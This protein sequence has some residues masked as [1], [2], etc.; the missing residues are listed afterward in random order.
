MLH[1]DELESLFQSLDTDFSGQ[2]SFD[3]FVRGLVDIRN[4]RQD[5]TQLEEQLEED[6]VIN[7]AYLD[8]CAAF[9]EADFQYKGQLDLSTFLEAM[10][11]PSVAES[12]SYA[13][14]L[15][16]GYFQSLGKI[17]KERLFKEIDK[18]DSGA[19]SFEE[20]VR[21]LVDAR[22]A[23]YQQEKV[24]QQEAEFA[25]QLAVEAFEDADDDWS[26][27]L[28]IEKFTHAFKFNSSFLSKVSEA[29]GVDVRDLAEFQ[30]VDIEDLFQK[31]DVDFSG[32][33]S[34]Q[35]FVSGLMQA[36]LAIHGAGSQSEVPQDANR[37]QLPE[38]ILQ[39]PPLH[40]AEKTLIDEAL[41]KLKRRGITIER[42]P[43]DLSQLVQEL[44]LWAPE[45][46]A[47]A[48]IEEA[49]PGRDLARDFNEP[50]DWYVLYQAVLSRQPVWTKPLTK[51]AQTTEPLTARDIQSHESS[52]RRA[53]DKF[54]G[55]SRGMDADDLGDFFVQAGL[56]DK[57]MDLPR[58]LS[59]FTRKRKPGCISFPE[60]V[61]LCNDVISGMLRNSSNDNFAGLLR[62][63][64]KRAYSGKPQPQPVPQPQPGAVSPRKPPP[65]PS[66]GQVYLGE[67]G[68]AWTGN[69]R[70]MSWIG[71]AR[72]VMSTPRSVL[73][74][75]LPPL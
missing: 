63:H 32:T 59:D 25:A 24:E 16:L 20:W 46:M 33:V 48:V 36:R 49:F 30:T 53:Y 5:A 74:A 50:D 70:G 58:I 8:A 41:V 66:L 72:S 6:A 47:K 31:L 37:Y 62:V 56:L 75:K 35:E 34:F 40:D 7:Q 23:T 11:D 65:L 12:L 55:N 68:A 60:V 61:E 42:K 29:T 54:A 26:G 18:D 69:R 1:D 52:M 9:E 57:D 15:P 71:S 67:T 64:P 39:L 27:K 10:S 13:T 51:S 73:H 44:Y 17:D 38:W 14:K 19:I 22:F 2:L 28:D 43:C 4:L 45:E 21:A 3:E